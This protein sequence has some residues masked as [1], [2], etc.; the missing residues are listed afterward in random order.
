[1]A[2]SGTSPDNQ[3]VMQEIFK[4]IQDFEGLYQVSNLGRVKSLKYRQQGREE[5][6]SLT[7][8][9]YGY[10]WVRLC[11]KRS[12]VHRLV[13]L[14]FIDKVEGKDFVNH[15]NGNKADNRVENL[16][17][18]TKSE[19]SIHSFEV[20]TQCNKGEQHPSHV[21]TAKEVREIRQKFQP[22][23]YTRDMLSVEYGVKP[24]TI[25]A[26]VLRK[27]WKHIAA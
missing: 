22:K 24:S 8:N 9:S 17:W 4:D 27:L 26:I 23:V 10:Q 3:L 2:I 21:L 14:A 18:V 15:I 12:S 20:G 19:N 11:K 13:A 1:M 7:A 6:L 5:M 25:K 16:E